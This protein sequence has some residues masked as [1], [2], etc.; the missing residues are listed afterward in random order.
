MNAAQVVAAM[1]PGWNLGNTFDYHTRGN[2]AGYAIGHS[3][4]EVETRWHTGNTPTSKALID[5]VRAAGF[6]TIRIPVTWYK[7]ADPNN[8]WNICPIWMARVKEVVDMAVAN[9]MYIIINTHHEERYLPL[10]FN[11]RTNRPS[12][13]VEGDRA[14]ASLYVERIWTQ[15]ATE[16]RSYNQK[17]IF[18]GLNEPRTIGSSAEWTGGTITERQSLNILNQVFVD[19]VRATG[20]NNTHRILA[21]PTVAASAHIAAF[22]GLVIPTDIVPDRIA[23]SIHSYTPD[24][25]CLSG[26]LGVTTEFDSANSMHTGGIDG[27]MNRLANESSRLG[28]P[29]IL[30]EWGSSNKNNQEARAV[31]A[32]YYTRAARAHGFTVVWWDDATHEPSF[33]SEN[34]GLFDRVTNVAH[35]PEIIAAIIRGYS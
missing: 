16:F 13:D 10:G 8:N 15:I 27:V 22:D 4:S 5:A 2:S 26:S 32:E 7:F 33:V 20:G 19:A 11:N 18:E 29:V 14:A 9:D 25:F 3:I 28:V 17:L 35:Y 1:G 23:L 6:T 31:H 24:G 21:I 34:F 12:E 30:S